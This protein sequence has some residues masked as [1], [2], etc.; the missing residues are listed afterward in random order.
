MYGL[1]PSVM[2]S[3]VETNHD[4]G[5][6]KHKSA[7]FWKGKPGKFVEF[8]CFENYSQVTKK[9]ILRIVLGEN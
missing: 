8:L 1:C 6:Y 7:L 5:M 3:V 2:L 4:M 9:L